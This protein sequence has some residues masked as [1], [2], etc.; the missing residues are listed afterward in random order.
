[1]PLAFKTMDGRLPKVLKFVIGH[2]GLGAGLNA[3]IRALAQVVDVFNVSDSAD[4][5]CREVEA[6]SGTRFDPAVVDTFRRCAERAD[7]REL[8][9]SPD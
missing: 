7:F 2:A 5:A 8:L 9:A 4:A 1:M 6:R 3:R